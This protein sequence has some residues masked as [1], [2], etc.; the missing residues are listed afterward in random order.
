MTGEQSGWLWLLIDVGA[1]ALLGLALAYGMLHWRKGRS[2][3]DV[4]AGDEATRR[5]YQEDPEADRVDSPAIQPAMSLE[6]DARHTEDEAAQAALGGPR[7]APELKPARM[8]PQREKKTPRSLDP[9]H[10]A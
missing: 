7:G 3:R 6:P 2:R 1:V 8:T 5:L 9:G 4:A 10:T